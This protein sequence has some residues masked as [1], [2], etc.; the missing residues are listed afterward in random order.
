MHEQMFANEDPA[1]RFHGP[2]HRALTLY[3]SGWA[4]N[5]TAVGGI[6]VEGLRALRLA[7]RILDRVPQDDS[8]GP[9]CRAVTVWL[10]VLVVRLTC[11]MALPG[12]SPSDTN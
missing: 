1:A 5:I 6:G 2:D 10:G 7:A 8:A 4:R 12:S 9:V 3:V 11:P